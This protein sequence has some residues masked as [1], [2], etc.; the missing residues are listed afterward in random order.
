V[1][2]PRWWFPIRAETPTLDAPPPQ[3]WAPFVTV[4]KEKGGQ[5][6]AH[7][8]PIDEIVHTADKEGKCVCGPFMV[9]MDGFPIFRHWPIRHDYYESPEGPDGPLEVPL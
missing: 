7:M 9:D 1:I 8:V 3:G 2:D 4:D 6:S 5:T